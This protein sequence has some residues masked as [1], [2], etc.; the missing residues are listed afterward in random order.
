VSLLAALRAAC[1]PPAAPQGPLG[2]AAVP[3]GPPEGGCGPDPFVYGP[4]EARQGP[5]A[6]P[7]EAQR[8]VWLDGRLVAWQRRIVQ[9]WIPLDGEPDGPAVHLHQ[10]VTPSGNQVLAGLHLQPLLEDLAARLGVPS[11]P[12][13]G[14]PMLR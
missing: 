4:W 9:P 11:R 12:P 5:E 1:A 7:G 2:A 14:P 6:A 10:L 13:Q 8:P 3:Q